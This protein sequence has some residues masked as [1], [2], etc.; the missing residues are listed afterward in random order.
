MIEI[1]MIDVNKPKLTVPIPKTKFSKFL[2]LIEHPFHFVV[3]GTGDD[4]KLNLIIDGQN[5]KHVVWLEA[6]GT[7]HAS[8]E[9]TP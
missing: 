8:T 4:V 3:Q 9:I 5:T 1:T 7:W 2:A 6:D